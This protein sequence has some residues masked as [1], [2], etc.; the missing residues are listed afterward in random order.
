MID[1][2]MMMDIGRIV[3]RLRRRSGGPSSFNAALD[4]F[5]ASYNSRS[6]D[7]VSFNICSCCLSMM[8]L[9]LAAESAGLMSHG[10]CGHCGSIKLVCDLDLLKLYRAAGIPNDRIRASMPLLRQDFPTRPLLCENAVLD[11][12]ERLHDQRVPPFQSGEIG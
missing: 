11:H 2:M 7:V 8:H 9:E 6:P 10:L 3:E 4:A 1:L 5:S 12:I